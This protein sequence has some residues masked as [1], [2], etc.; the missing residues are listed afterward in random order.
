MR[1]NLTLFILLLLS[2]NAYS[3]KMTGIWRGYFS[4]ANGVYREGS[5]DENY[6]YEIQIDQQSNNG[7]RGVTYSYKTT[8]FYGKAEFQGIFTAASKSIILKESRLVDL[9]IGDKS[10]PCLMTCYLDYSKIGKLEVLE[11]TF[12]SINAK[13][14]GDCGSWKVYLERVAT[15]DFKK[16]DFL[17]KKK[18]EDSVKPTPKETI[19]AAKSVPPIAAKNKPVL[20]PG[21]ESPAKKDNLTSKTIPLNSAKTALVKPPAVATPPK[22]IPPVS[23][24]NK[25]ID[26]KNAIV[27]TT[28]PVQPEDKSSTTNKIT[29]RIQE[30]GINTKKEEPKAALS[31]PEAQIRKMPIPRVLLE[32]ENNLVKTITTSEEELQVEFYDYGTIDNDTITVYHNNELVANH[33]RLS[34]TP[35]IIKIKCSKTDNHHEIIVVADNLGDIPPNSA[36]MIIKGAKFSKERH[37]IFLESNEQKNAKVVIN[38]V[39]KE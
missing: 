27:K 33:R 7:L 3:Q 15:S 11:G 32:R 4:S 24:P 9:K 30:E 6:K 16:E 23:T 22:T 12:I 36:L 38:Y 29:E 18:P 34:L 21:A 28:K 14:K 1:L 37:E 20:K 10:E 17:N 5:R 26:T 31:Q 39:P 35:I 19:T 8:V 25:K 2:F 13:D